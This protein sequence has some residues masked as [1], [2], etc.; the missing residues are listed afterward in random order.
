LLVFLELVD[1]PVHDALV[2]VVAAQVGITIGRLDLDHAL[3]DFQHGN[4]KGSAAEV[5]DDDRFVFLL[6]Q[7]V[8]QRRRGGLVDDALY[9]QTGNL[10]CVFGR[11]ALSIVEVR[12]HGDDCF[13]NRRPEIVFC[14]LFQLLQ[15]HCRDLRR[16][17]FLAL[18]YDDHVVALLP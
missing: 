17:V 5:I 7:P 13:R 14:S 3:A 2:K 9:V 1:Q 12:R 18:G 6:I 15:N 8:G 4:V 11:L 10:A 16:G